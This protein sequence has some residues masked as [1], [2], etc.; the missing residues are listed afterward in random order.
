MVF[1]QVLK[2]ILHIAMLQ[3]LLPHLL[4]WKELQYQAQ[5]SECS[6]GGVLWR[7]VDDYGVWSRG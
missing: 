1:G 4:L 7:R 5:I 3:T 6:P 2:V